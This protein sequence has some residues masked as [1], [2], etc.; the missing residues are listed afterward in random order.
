MEY[1]YYAYIGGSWSLLITMRAVKT[2]TIQQVEGFT[3]EDR[4]QDPQKT[5]VSTRG[6]G[7]FKS[8]RDEMNHVFDRFSNAQW[9]L[10]VAG[11]LTMPSPGAAGF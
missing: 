7:G 5:E 6:S 4:K 2:F 3:M 1:R 9:P 10:S 11:A 8:L